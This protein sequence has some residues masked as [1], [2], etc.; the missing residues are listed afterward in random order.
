MARVTFPDGT[1]VDCDVSEVLPLLAA[2]ARRC[3]DE[4]AQKIRDAISLGHQNRAWKEQ[5]SREI[6]E[7]RTE[8][9]RMELLADDWIFKEIRTATFYGKSFIDLG[10]CSPREWIIEA[11]RRIPG[12][13][14]REVAADRYSTV[15]RITWQ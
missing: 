10:G 1:L 9:Y 2:G 15:A 14:G 6:V 7:E 12:F 8:K 5:R 11:V 3:G 13:S 4:N